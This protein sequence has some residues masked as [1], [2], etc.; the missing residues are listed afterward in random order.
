MFIFSSKFSI[1]LFLPRSPAS[2]YFYVYSV[3]IKKL[4]LSFIVFFRWEFS[5]I[6]KFRDYFHIK[7]I[8]KI[9]CIIY[10]TNP[11]NIVANTSNQSNLFPYCLSLNS[12]PI[13]HP[14]TH[15]IVKTNPIGIAYKKCLSLLDSFNQLIENFIKFIL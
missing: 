15:N 6:L 1:L 3:L 12:I 5:G 11:P 10:P 9:I 13:A 8:T 7:N 2:I 14:R 4:L